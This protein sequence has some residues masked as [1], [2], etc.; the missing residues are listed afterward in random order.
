MKEFNIEV[1]ETLSRV[2]TVKAESLDEALKEVFDQYDK[3]EIVLEYKD[4]KGY[5]IVPY[6]E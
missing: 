4:F 6:A 1:I 2:V 3:Q 5:D